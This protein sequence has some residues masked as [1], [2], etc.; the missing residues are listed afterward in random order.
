MSLM[1]TVVLCSV[2]ECHDV[3]CLSD[4]MLAVVLRGKRRN[5]ILANVIL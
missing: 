4:K 3:L 1:C 2:I 5:I